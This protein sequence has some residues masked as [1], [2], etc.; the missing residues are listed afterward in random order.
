MNSIDSSEEP[1]RGEKNMKKASL[2]AL[3]ALVAVLTIE[4][5]AFGGTIEGTIKARVRRLN[6]IVVYIDK[7]G[8]NTEFS[9]PEEHAV[10]DQK[11]LTFVPHV[12]PV[13]VG[14]TV[15]FL[16]S[17]DIL[18]NVFSPDKMAGRFNL[19]TYS[20]GNKK[21]VTF[22]RP[23]DVVVLC[24]VHAEMEGYIVVV[25]TPYFA[26][27]DKTGKYTIPNVPAGTYTLKT[28]HKKLKEGSLVVTVPEEGAM[29]ADFSLRR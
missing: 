7:A 21:S 15:D 29:Q 24:N 8:L 22:I 4:S 10:M 17:D 20:K 23:G 3:A 27:T 28:W 26:V 9:P 1:E 19:G 5:V 14:T 2:T 16:N 11:N 6:N 18:H 13:L 25:E 12:M